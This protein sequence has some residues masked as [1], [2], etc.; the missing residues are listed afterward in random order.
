MKLR[1]KLLVDWVLNVHNL[2]IKIPV[3]IIALRTA[4]KLYL[5]NFALGFPS[6]ELVGLEVVYSNWVYYVIGFLY[7]F[8]WVV[9]PTEIHFFGQ[10]LHL[11]PQNTLTF[12]H[13]GTFEKRKFSLDE[14]LEIDIVLKLVPRPKSLIAVIHT[15]RYKDRF[16]ELTFKV[17]VGLDEIETGGVEVIEGKISNVSL[18]DVEKFVARLMRNGFVAEKDE[19]PDLQ[20]YMISRR[21]F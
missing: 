2:D 15:L 11:D 3:T 7:L 19:K 13:R 5:V 16:G 12:K 4:Y 21:G 18:H 6:P 14:I 1:D 8:F 20:A 9:Y 10:M 17:V